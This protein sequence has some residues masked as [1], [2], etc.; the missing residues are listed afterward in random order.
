MTDAER[1]CAAA[2]ALVAAPPHGSLAAY[3]PGTEPTLQL[4]Q[5]Q[6]LTLDQDAVL[7]EQLSEELD[8]RTMH[9]EAFLIPG[10]GSLLEAPVA[11]VTYAAPPQGWMPA[12][13]AQLAAEKVALKRQLRQ[14]D[15]DFE[16][17]MSSLL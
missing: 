15:A 10:S 14:L 13:A 12:A 17:R 16:V 8:E 1:T 7:L 9:S 2:A 4:Q 3:S 6:Q 11:H 5:L